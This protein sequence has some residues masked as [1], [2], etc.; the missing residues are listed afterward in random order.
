MQDLD[1]N[2]DDFSPARGFPLALDSTPMGSW[3]LMQPT[4]ISVF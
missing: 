4:A 3:L 2:G 1:L